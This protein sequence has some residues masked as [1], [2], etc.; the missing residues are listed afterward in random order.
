[1]NGGRATATK[2]A[3]FA[4]MDYVWNVLE[5]PSLLTMD[6]SALQAGLKLIVKN[7]LVLVPIYAQNVA[8]PTVVIYA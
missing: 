4:T 8:V 7:G 2:N 5:M 6:V 3:H 1:M